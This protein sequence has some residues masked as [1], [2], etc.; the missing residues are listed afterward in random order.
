MTQEVIYLDLSNIHKST[1]NHISSQSKI[2]LF[3]C[4]VMVFL[5]I[6]IIYVTYIINF[7]DKILKNTYLAGINI[8][9]LTKQQAAELMEPLIVQK[10]YSTEIKLVNENTPN[11]V[12]EQMSTSKQ[13]NK[14]TQQTNTNQSKIDSQLVTLDSTEIYYNELNI[15]V[16]LDSSIIECFNYGRNNSKIF[17]YNIHD[18]I[19]SHFKRTDFDLQITYYP[20]QIK[21]LLENKLSKYNAISVDACVEF[22]E[23]TQQPIITD[24]IVGKEV[25]INQTYS[26]L[27]KSVIKNLNDL[28]SVL[29]DNLDSSTE[30]VIGNNDTDSNNKG[31]ST[32][33]YPKTYIISLDIKYLKALGNMDKPKITSE[34]L[35]KCTDLL[36]K[37]STSFSSSAINRNKNIETAVNK[38]N[39]SIVLPGKTFSLYVNTS[40]YTIENGYTEAGVIRGT[41]LTSD[42]GGGVCQVATTLYNAV[43]RSELEVTSR[44]N[45]IYPAN[46]VAPGFDATVAGKDIDFI[47]RNNLDVPVIINMYVE[48][49]T[50]Q[51][52]IYSVDE[53]PSNRTIEYHSYFN[54][55]DNLWYLYKYIYID[56]EFEKREFVDTSKYKS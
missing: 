22:E 47:F 35:N 38:I 17:T 46:Y 26:K 21:T 6:L 52:K 55:E 32:K 40:P 16:D 45:H 44:T 49:N 24:E 31:I 42:V 33:K 37:S 29:Q 11:S 48:D 18:V 15:S 30:S 51:C 4:T 13:S 1:H 3:M 50:I 8:G 39:N 27:M 7:S 54:N 25:D 14:S 28:D 53:R 10:Q 9:G 12:N 43:L 20:S 41:E 56:G 36:G 23:I 5:F 19:V 2:K 34:Q